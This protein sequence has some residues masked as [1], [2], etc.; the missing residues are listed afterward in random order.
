[1][2]RSYK[3]ILRRVL[4]TIPTMF[5]VA[6]MVFLLLNV[7]PGDEITALYGSD[8]SAA[9]LVVIRQQFGLN[10]PLQIRYLH[11]FQGLLTG[12]LG[13][14]ISLNSNVSTLIA[15]RLPVTLTLTIFTII[16]AL[17]IAI[18]I[19]V[20]SAVKRNSKTDTSLS[21]FAMLGLSVPGFYLGIV[22]ILVFSVWNKILPSGGYVPFLQNPIDCIYH[23]ILPATTLGF[24]LVAYI[25]R[26]TRSSLLETL[27]Q[28]FILVLRAKGL[29][30]RAILFRHALRNS[31]VNVTT[32][33]GLQVGVLL[34]GSLVIEDVFRIPG[35]GSLLLTAVGDRDF[36]IV[37]AAILIYALLVVMTNLAVDILYVRL[38]PRVKLG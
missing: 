19:G 34:G 30:E 33:V 3:F 7:I 36:A 22:A 17:A 4:V 8:V 9:E 37:T 1:L 6:T 27:S 10:Y 16:I 2:A 24:I 25:M 32:A 14:S 11:Y 21:I 31:L 26:M 28:E 18:P 38:D 13:Y 12:N 35:M 20:V 23:M 29:S 15:Y 5:A